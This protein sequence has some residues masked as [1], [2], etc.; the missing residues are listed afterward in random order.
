MRTPMTV[1][2]LANDKARTAL[3]NHIPM[4]R[5]GEAEELAGPAVFLASRLASYVTGV[6]LPVDGGYLAV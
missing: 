4:R 5:V 6:M 3:M 2:T 1:E